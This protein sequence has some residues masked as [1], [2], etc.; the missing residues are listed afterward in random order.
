MSFTFSEG[1]QP[2][3]YAV[4]VP[5][6]PFFAKSDILETY[7]IFVKLFLISTIPSGIILLLHVFGIQSIVPSYTIFEGRPFI[8]FPGTVLQPMEFTNIAGITFYRISGI[9][10]EPGG[11]G[12]ISILIL[13][14][15]KMNLN[16]RSNQYILAIGLISFSLAFYVL[17]IL[18][19]L[20]EI[21]F[22]KSQVS[23]YKLVVIFVFLGLILM[24][25]SF[26][27]YY[28]GKRVSDIDIENPSARNTRTSVTALDFFRKFLN[29]DLNAIMIGHGYGGN[30]DI[31]AIE[32]AQ[33]INYMAYFY[34]FGLLN[35]FSLFFLIFLILYKKEY[36]SYSIIALLIIISS[37]YQRPYIFNNG[38]LF[39]FFALSYRSE[40]V[41][42]EKQS[43]GKVRQVISPLIIK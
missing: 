33:G 22:D 39:L 11:L 18:Y 23:K 31:S 17:L 40:E 35:V 29:Q 12:A 14:A 21:L 5:L 38:Y 13:M 42:R 7:K 27:E 34:N 25:S 9:M 37:F 20:L 8:V 15:E 36:R 24:N 26:Y 2:L 28:I 3:K 1:F 6:L 10:G 43:L 41:S 30:I 4:I 19:F 32:G 16:K